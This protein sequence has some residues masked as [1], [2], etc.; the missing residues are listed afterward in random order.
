MRLDFYN[1]APNHLTTIQMPNGTGKTTTLSLL[2]YLFSG[3][4]LSSQ[5]V[6]NYRPTKYEANEGRASMKIKIDGTDFTIDLYLDY[7]EET[8][9][10]T[11]NSLMIGGFEEG[12]HIPKAY[13]LSHD[14][15]NLFVFNGEVATDLFKSS[16]NAAEQS[17]DC[18]YGLSKVEDIS[19]RAADLKKTIKSNSATKI[20]KQ[21]SLEK[22]RQL[23]MDLRECL[24]N[25][26]NEIEDNEQRISEIDGILEEI[27]VEM[28]RLQNPEI[29]AKLEILRNDI[30]KHKKDIE[31]K[32]GELKSYAV[33]PMAISDYYSVALNS[34]R[35]NMDILKLPRGT[36]KEFFEEL[37][38]S[39]SC[40]CG[41]K[42]TPDIQNKIRLN[43]EKYLSDEMAGVMNSVKNDVVNF[44]DDISTV[45]QLILDINNLK[46]KLRDEIGE[47][48]RLTKSTG[49]L[50]SQS[51]YEDLLDKK[52]KLEHEKKECQDSI[53]FATDV[54]LNP[55][56]QTNITL[57][58]ERIAELEKEIGLGDEV[59]KK[60]AQCDNT[61]KIFK[62]IYDIA[63]KNLKDRVIKMTNET[64][65]PILG[66]EII[67]T[68]ID[69]SI[70]I[71]DKP[72]GSEGQVLTTGY[73]YISALFKDSQY[74]L[75][76]IIDS[77][78]GSLDLDKRAYVARKIPGLF[79]QIVF[80]VTS[81][82]RARF[83]DVL[84]KSE[85]IH[86]YTI[87]RDVKNNSIDLTVSQ[88]IDYFNNFQIE[89][90]EVL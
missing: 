60:L 43:S 51:R 57:C 16:K 8:F 61:A 59:V 37:C 12:H 49:G 32:T 76:F 3:D 19:K 77:P 35:D 21:S 88:D 73:A 26:T 85:D 6:L 42:M 39:D 63:M 1:D 46:L 22:K 20:S 40:I 14:L 25:L 4:A 65:F 10:Y 80:F 62:E 90:E 47:E 29:R 64:L 41:T 58:K 5:D 7:I 23:L 38:E 72:E 33:N 67:V 69:R 45:N 44:R 31:I 89:D 13:K 17:I 56:D 54:L 28:N 27:S 75:P 55:D 82:E 53:K 30:D 84:M 78:C 86:P 36:S 11:T 71:K 70:K 74:R 48:D 34:L 81:S 18:L 24:T 9:R 79:D 68:N 2:K 66:D 87:W 52:Y 50:Q 15:V 83:T